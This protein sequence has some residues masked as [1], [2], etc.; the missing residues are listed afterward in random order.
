[1]VEPLTPRVVAIC[2]SPN[3]HRRPRDS[4]PLSCAPRA[5]R[6]SKARS[7]HHVSD[8]LRSTRY[9]TFIPSLLAVQARDE[10]SNESNLWRKMLRPLSA[11]HHHTGAVLAFIYAYTASR[12]TTRRSPT[13]SDTSRVT[14][15][16]VHQMVLT[17]ERNGLVKRQS[18][19]RPQPSNS[20]SP[21][22]PSQSYV[23]THPNPSNPL[24]KRTR[25]MQRSKARR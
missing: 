21:L 20:S 3:P 4:A 9:R 19:G 15:P 22:R 12:T 10:S 1:M 24:G 8:W 7:V 23:D 18:G 2:S 17:L 14:A 11:L 13:C 6:R 5:G 25:W 16:T